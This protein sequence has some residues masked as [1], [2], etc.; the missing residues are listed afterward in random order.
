MERNN[1]PHQVVMS[2]EVYNQLMSYATVGAHEHGHE[3]PAAMLRH[4]RK[5]NPVLSLEHQAEVK[6]EQEK[7]IGYRKAVIA[8][9]GRKAGQK[10]YVSENG[11]VLKGMT[12]LSVVP[13]CKDR[14]RLRAT[15]TSQ[16]QHV[17]I[18]NVIESLPL[19][20]VFETEGYW[21]GCYLPWAKAVKGTGLRE[22][23]EAYE[24]EQAEARGY[25]QVNVSCRLKPAPDYPAKS[26]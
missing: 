11:D 10:V 24:K 22:N 4:I 6:L 18:S 16:E 3:L 8:L 19:G 25:V 5:F 26:E 13:G 17:H 15:R 23:R 14:V 1:D 20:H 9:L 2:R 21:R 7:F 12:L